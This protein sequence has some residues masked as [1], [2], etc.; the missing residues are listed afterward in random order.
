M[1][2]HRAIVGAGEL[3][4]GGLRCT[5]ADSAPDWSAPA[6]IERDAAAAIHREHGGLHARMHGLVALADEVDGFSDG[7]LRNRLDE[8]V[9]FLRPELLPHAHVEE[10]ALY[11]AVDRLLQATGGATTTMAVDRRAIAE[12]VHALAAAGV[13]EPVVRHD[14]RRLLHELHVLLQVHF[15]KEEQVYLPLLQRLT[16]DQHVDLLEQL[17]DA[18]QELAT[19]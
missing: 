10:A 13:R 14:V 9:L 8:I 1:R 5:G 2:H 6:P 16:A 15:D 3:R 17:H 4:A 12:R 11:P 19:G 18:H 7:Q